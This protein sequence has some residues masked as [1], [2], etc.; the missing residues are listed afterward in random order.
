MKRKK[1]V[2][3]PPLCVVHFKSMQLL[4]ARI[5]VFFSKANI[6]ILSQQKPRINEST[7]FVHTW[8][9]WNQ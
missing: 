1:K 9:H 5:F 3:S 8:N 6:K 4:T 7:V 2:I